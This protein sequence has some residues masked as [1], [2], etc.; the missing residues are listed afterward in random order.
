MSSFKNV[1]PPR[2]SGATSTT[3]SETMNRR[4]LDDRVG[5]C[6]SRFEARTQGLRDFVRDH[7][8]VIRTLCDLVG[9]HS[10]AVADLKAALKD[11][12]DT[13]K[14]TVRTTVGLVT[15]SRKGDT[16][17]WDV[18]GISP[19]VLAMPGVVTQINVDRIADLK[20]LGNITPDQIRDG[21]IK[22]SQGTGSSSVSG[23]TTVNL[24]PIAALLP[25]VSG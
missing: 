22:I 9:E 4:V 16:V 24:G 15:R 20:E 12:P 21:A 5:T 23:A 3:G 6:T 14:V 17:E 10:A 11:L 19:D 18:S 8:P 13:D 7:A 2:T 25:P 1:H